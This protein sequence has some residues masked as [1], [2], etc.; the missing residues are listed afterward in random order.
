MRLPVYLAKILTLF[1]YSAFRRR[2]LA[3]TFL[4]PRERPRLSLSLSLSSLAP[5]I[6]IVAKIDIL[7]RYVVTSG[8][9]N[10]DDE[11]FRKH[12]THTGGERIRYR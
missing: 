4:Q 10:C 12:R 6:I 7:I 2:L 8:R 5:L 1:C 3:F 11:D 9:I